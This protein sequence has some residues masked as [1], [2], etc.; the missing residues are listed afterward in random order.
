MNLN[1]I[2]ESLSQPLAEHTT[3]RTKSI[4]MTGIHESSNDKEC[5][6][7]CVYSRKLFTWCKEHLPMGDGIVVASIS[8]GQTYA[9]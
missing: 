4:T 1:L 6:Y 9:Q 3:L 7:K 8:F 5:E 2:N